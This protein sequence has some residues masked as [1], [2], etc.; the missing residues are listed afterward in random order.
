[1]EG[2]LT[3]Y[4]TAQALERELVLRDPR[5]LQLQSDLALTCQKVGDILRVQG[6]ISEALS[7]YREC[8]GLGENLVTKDPTNSQW[9]S[10]LALACYSAATTSFESP[11]KPNEEAR[12]LL[13]RARDLLVKLQAQNSLSPT[14]QRHLQEIQ[15]TLSGL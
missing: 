13:Q 7:S 5:T 6:H 4:R 15:A 8:V 12:T 10:E 14:D 1:M 2:V 3:D 9:T 11:E